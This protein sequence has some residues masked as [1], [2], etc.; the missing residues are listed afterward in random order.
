[1]CTEHHGGAGGRVI[2]VVSLGRVVCVA[3]YLRMLKKGSHGNIMYAN[4]GGKSGRI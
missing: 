4:S 2:V 3:G 1:M